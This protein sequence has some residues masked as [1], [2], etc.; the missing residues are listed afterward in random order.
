MDYEQTK[1]MIQRHEGYRDRVY[2]DTEGI[3]TVGYGHAFIVGS[4]VPFDVC[5][6]LFDYDFQSVVE[7]YDRL[8]LD[9]DSIRKAV[10]LDMLFNLGLPRLSKFVKFL[11][12][13]REKD[14]DRAAEEM[15]DSKW[16][17]QVGS[18]GRELVK[19]MEIGEDYI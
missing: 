5:N 15:R 1:E 17:R 8:S 10:L 12:A 4:K 16:F 14:Y 2:L 11:Q 3:P 6:K 18:R 9:L 19:M 13:L 7:D